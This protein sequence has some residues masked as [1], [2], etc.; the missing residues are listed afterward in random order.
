MMTDFRIKN[1]YMLL[2]NVE[3][4]INGFKIYG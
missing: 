4:I 3:A 2:L 1:V